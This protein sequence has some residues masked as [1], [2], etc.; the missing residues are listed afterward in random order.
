[1]TLTREPSCKPPLRRRPRVQSTIVNGPHHTMQHAPVKHEAREE[2]GKGGLRSDELDP[3][4]ATPRRR[5]KGRTR[6]MIANALK[7][8]DMT[9]HF[10]KSNTW[11]G[12]QRVLV[13]AVTSESCDQSEKLFE[14][15]HID[16]GKRHRET[17]RWHL[18]RQHGPSTAPRPNRVTDVYGT[19]VHTCRLGHHRP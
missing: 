19:H 13:W 15:R 9:R 3:P 5:A 18:S 14:T 4:R 10:P 16:T 12:Y 8:L 11:A 2:T 6:T 1:M 7:C 17:L